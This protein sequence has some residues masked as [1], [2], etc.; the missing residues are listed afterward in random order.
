MATCNLLKLSWY[1]FSLGGTVMSSCLVLP[2]GNQPLGK[3]TENLMNLR[4]AVSFPFGGAL[5]KKETHRKKNIQRND[6]V[7][8]GGTYRGQ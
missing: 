2:P 4:K 5:R 1:I 6:A 8:K 7:L 3:D